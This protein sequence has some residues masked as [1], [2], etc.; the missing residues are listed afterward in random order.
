[1]FGLVPFARSLM[2]AVNDWPWNGRLE[3]YPTSPVVTDALGG[4]VI[5]ATEEAAEHPGLYQA[6]TADA[7]TIQLTMRPGFSVDA[8]TLADLSMADNG[9][10]GLQ[11]AG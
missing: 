3:T 11:N 1:M 7:Y 10:L 6:Y 5:R 9:G 8:Q 2:M 4:A